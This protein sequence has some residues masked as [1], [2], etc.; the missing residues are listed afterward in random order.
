[1]SR[2]NENARFNRRKPF[3]EGISVS[4]NQI[5]GDDWFKANDRILLDAHCACPYP[6]PEVALDDV[7]VMVKSGYA[8]ITVAR[9]RKRK[10]ATD[11]TYAEEDDADGHLQSRRRKLLPCEKSIVQDFY[12][13]KVEEL[14]AKLGAEGCE[15]LQEDREARVQQKLQQLNQELLLTGQEAALI[16]SIA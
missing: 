4:G 15:K 14:Q 5:Q 16:N 1:M 6:G 2:R 10:T 11:Q 3:V 7:L 9:P 12:D 13:E 8:Q